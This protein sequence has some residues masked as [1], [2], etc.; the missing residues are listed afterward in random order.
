MAE[1]Q[2]IVRSLASRC[3][4]IINIIV[5]RWCIVWTWYTN[6]IVIFIKW[7]HVSFL[8]SIMPTNMSIIQ[9]GMIDLAYRNISENLSAYMG[10]VFEEI[11]K[12]YL[13]LLNRIGKVAVTFLDLGRWWGGDPESKSEVEIDI[14]A[15]GETNSA[16]FCE[17][18]WTNED[19]DTSVLVTLIKRSRFFA[20]EKK[21]FCKMWIYIWLCKKG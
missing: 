5:I 19:M 9:N 18:K 15:I 21:Y 4:C 8:V 11:C 1:Y 14:L 2:S 20:Y 10:F 17:C 12:Q 7:Q 6:L 13:W 3:K 16:I